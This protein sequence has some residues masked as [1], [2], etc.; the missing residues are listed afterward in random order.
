MPGKLFGGLLIEK[1]FKKRRL[2]CKQVADDRR[3]FVFRRRGDGVCEVD[4]E[5]LPPIAHSGQ[6]M[7]LM[8][9]FG[10][11]FWQMC[12]GLRCAIPI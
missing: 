1:C 7:L 6:I 5:K 2:E 3:K 10:F 12:W 11:G 8:R 9:F 4:E